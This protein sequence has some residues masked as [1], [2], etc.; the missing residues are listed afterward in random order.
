MLIIEYPVSRKNIIEYLSENIFLNFLGI[1][2]KASPNTD[3]GQIVI[4][5]KNSKHKLILKS[6]S[7]IENDPFQLQAYD[8][9]ESHIHSIYRKNN[10]PLFLNVDYFKPVL[11]GNNISI[12]EDSIETD[13][14]IFGLIFFMLSRVEELNRSEL[15]IHGRFTAKSSKAYQHGFLER[16]IVDEYV[17]LLWTLMKYLWPNLDR[18]EEKPNTIVGCD[19]DTPYDCSSKKLG[20][21]IRPLIGDVLKRTDIPGAFNRIKRFIN[22]RVKNEIDSTDDINYTFDWYMDVVES[23]GLKATFFFIADNTDGKSG[24]YSLKE[25]KIKLLIKKIL[26]RGH[27]IG[28]HGSYSSYN[29][30]DKL[31]LEKNTIQSTVNDIGYDYKIT[32]SRQHYLRWD[33]QTTI[34]ILDKAG[35]LVDHT[36]SYADHI[37][38]RYGTS[39]RFRAFSL[40]QGKILNIMIQPL[41]IM[42]NSLFAEEYQGL[43]YSKDTASYLNDIINKALR[44]GGAF[45]MLW[46]NDNF[47]NPLDATFFKLLLESVNTDYN[48]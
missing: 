10:S 31:I 14:D 37:G 35:I 26:D 33:P 16:P 32:E 1:D 15:D 39:K 20:M 25:N 5:H 19:V 36:G 22:F 17:E 13:I 44:Y 12:S 48:E 8:F 42:D 28:L 47:K 6:L 34:D 2:Y 23:Y 21:L 41:H 38:F 30:Q 4:R 46:H 3:I 27:H 18:K 7:L 45:S 43:K 11:K 24:C 9:I 29:S 40:T